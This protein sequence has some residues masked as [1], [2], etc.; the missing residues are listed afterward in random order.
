VIGRFST[1]G[2][3]VD[4]TGVPIGMGKHAARLLVRG[5]FIG[6]AQRETLTPVNMG[7]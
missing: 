2:L 5:N 3:A 4:S 1:D 6:V 7:N